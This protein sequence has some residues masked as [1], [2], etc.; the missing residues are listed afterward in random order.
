MSK[1]K[2]IDKE[3]LL[4]DSSLNV[5]SYRLLTSGYLMDEFKKNPIGYNMHLRDKGVVVRWDDFRKDGDKVYAKPVINLSNPDGQKVADEIENGFLNAASVG[6][7][8][9]L[10]I[11]SDPADYLPDQKGPT[12][13]KWFNRECSLVDIPGN[14]NALTDLY[15]AHDNKLDLADFTPNFNNNMKQILLTAEQILKLN[16]KADADQGA[17]DAAFNNLVAEAAKVPDLQAKLTKAENDKTTAETAL[18]DLKKAT[19]EQTINDLVAAGVTDGKITKEAGEKLK[20]DYATNPDGLKSLMDMMPKY[21]PISQQIT[22]SAAADDLSA[23]S[24]AELDKSGKLEDLK[25]KDINLFKQKYKD[26]FGK[27]YQ[28]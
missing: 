15:D 6:H 23:K 27:E 4:T 18:A 19:T 24:W 13:K 2:K 11:S 22:G 3:F 16:L 5:Y 10:E 7:I 14:Y 17:V 21:Q 26:Q 20:V 9:A 12:I 1:L 28:G 25:A 8:V